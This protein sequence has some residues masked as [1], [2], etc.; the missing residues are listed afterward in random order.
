MPNVPFRFYFSFTVL[1]IAIAIV[2]R[3]P[4][5]FAQSLAGAKHHSKTSDVRSVKSGSATQARDNLEA[6]ATHELMLGPGDLTTGVLPTPATVRSRI[7]DVKNPVHPIVY[8][9]GVSVQP[10]TPAG[11]VQV[12]DLAPYD[13]KSAGTTAM[14][15]LEGQ[16]L[17]FKFVNMSGLMAG[18]FASVGFAQST[19]DLRSPT[20]A[21]IDN[22]KLNA[23]KAQLG[24]TAAYQIPE[25]PLWSVHG[26]LGL[27]RL[28]VIQSS[29]SSFAN[30]S[31]SLWFAS[32]GA[33]V[34]RALMPNVSVYVAYDFRAAVSG[35]SD[36]A[37]VSRHNVLL[38]LLGNFE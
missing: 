33:S 24:A 21:A 22:T 4:L 19:L 7:E 16:W 28:T 18:V 8:R 29:T 1:L 13:L 3:S 15:A 2:V 35:S 23:I 9:L 26:N 25:S 38:G 5:A 10:Y 14:V 37:D 32:L 17:P 30:M 20:G 31:T 11:T 12:S 34:E 36:G 6:Q 27:G